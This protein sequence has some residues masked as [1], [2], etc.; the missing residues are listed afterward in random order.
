MAEQAKT[1]KSNCKKAATRCRGVENII[2]N[3]VKEYKRYNGMNDEQRGG[4]DLLLDHVRQLQKLVTKYSKRNFIMRGLK[5]NSFKSSYEE[6][7]KEISTDIQIIQMGLGVKTIQ[8]NN[9]L[10]ESSKV[11]MEE[12]NAKL[13]EI[14]E[15]LNAMNVDENHLLTQLLSYCPSLNSF[16]LFIFSF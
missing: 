7:D 4:F 11:N 5:A 6:L 1:N 9:D 15:R 16:S 10:L 13:E 12:L 14:L 3:C 2:N 8:L